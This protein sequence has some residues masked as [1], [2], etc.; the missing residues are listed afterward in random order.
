M[1]PRKRA[2]D[3]DEEYVYEGDD[4]DIPLGGER[5]KG[6]RAAPTKSTPT[7]LGPL[8]DP[9]VIFRDYSKSLTEA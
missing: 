1:G 9:E 5:K 6:K 8:D 2:A 4:Y 3:D 7:S